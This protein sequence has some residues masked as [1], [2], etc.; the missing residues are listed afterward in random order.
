M[1][2]HA[3]AGEVGK[4]AEES[5]ASNFEVLHEIATREPH[6][7]LVEIV[8]C[9]LAEQFRKRFTLDFLPAC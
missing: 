7:F 1:C 3:N 9:P 2:L 4:I 5:A 8:G 6:G